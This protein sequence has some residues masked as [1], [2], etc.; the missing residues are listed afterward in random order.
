M[1][2]RNAGTPPRIAVGAV[3]L[4]ADGTVQT[5]DVLVKVTPEG[6]GAAGSA[7][8]ISYVEGIVHYAPT[9]AETNY[10]AFTVTA[11][12]AACIPATVSI[13]TTAVA[14]AGTVSVLEKA[15]TLDLSDTEKESVQSIATGGLS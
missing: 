3:V 14:T 13:V 15:S 11:Y 2:P 5:A 7:G 6:G 9:Q 1:F 4:I 12:K 8:T 10:T